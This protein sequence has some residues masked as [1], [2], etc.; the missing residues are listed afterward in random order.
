[1][2]SIIIYRCV[3]EKAGG[4]SWWEEELLLLSPATLATSG[5]GCGQYG[6]GLGLPAFTSAT[7][8]LGGFPS[9]KGIQMSS[10]PRGNLCKVRCP[11]KMLNDV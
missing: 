1:M 10:P 2:K 11:G 8:I 5:L 3:A 6:Q 7:Y 9:R 4:L